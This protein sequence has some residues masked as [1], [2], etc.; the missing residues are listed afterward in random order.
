MNLLRLILFIPATIV[1]FVLSSLII[2]FLIDLLK[3]F[4]GEAD[5]LLRF[6]W[7]P[8]T[9][10]A[11]SLFI[12]FG[13]GIIIFPYEKKRLTLMLILTVLFIGF[14]IF[15][16]QSLQTSLEIFDEL[17]MKKE[18]KLV[19]IELISSAIGLLLSLLYSWKVFYIDEK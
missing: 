17:D 1:T 8:F 12:A 13:V 15:I 16:F 2:G 19:R 5:Y 7:Q 14:E 4:E 18:Y 11:F 10:S 6:L 3:Y 9:Q